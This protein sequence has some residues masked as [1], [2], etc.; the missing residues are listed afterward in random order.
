MSS[1]T[2]YYAHKR[3]MRN[4]QRLAQDQAMVQ[5]KPCNGTAKMQIRVSTIGS[6]E[7]ETVTSIACVHCKDGLVNPV[8]QIYS[9]LVW[10]R[11]KARSDTN[12]VCATDGR[13]VFGN[14]TYLCG[15]CGFVK[16][17]G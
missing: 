13:R 15:A 5:C 17:F 4:A 12:F 16:Q 8:N 3:A 6:T 7:P 14:D 11:C 1:F 2:A 10:C 9:A